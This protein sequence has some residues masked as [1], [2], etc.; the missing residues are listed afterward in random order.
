MP[1]SIDT[2]FLEQLEALRLFAQSARD[3]TQAEDS[4]RWSLPRDND[5]SL[6]PW[7]HPAIAAVFSRAGINAMYQAAMQGDGSLGDCAA[8]ALQ[9]NQL[10]CA[11]RAYRLRSAS[12][13][14]L[15]AWRAA[16]QAG[17]AHA[18]GILARL[19]SQAQ[20]LIAAGIEP[21]GRQQAPSA[22]QVRANESAA[23]ARNAEADRL[24]GGTVSLGGPFDE[25]DTSPGS[26]A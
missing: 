18:S 15:S 13:V 9:G 26:T 2:V 21:G 11:E 10:A 24:T 17:H 23:D 14:R 7:D 16:R 6:S 8:L 25:N 3:A 12:R 22:E 5:A 19:V 20:N 1:A 4:R